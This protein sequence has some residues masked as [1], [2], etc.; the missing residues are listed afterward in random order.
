M[1]LSIIKY[2][3]LC[4]VLLPGTPFSWG[5]WTGWSGCSVTCGSGAQTQSR[6]CSGTCGTYCQGSATASMSCFAGLS[7]FELGFVSSMKYLA[8]HTILL[9]P[10]VVVEHVQW[11]WGCWITVSNSIM[12]WCMWR[13]LQWT[14]DHHT[15]LH[16]WF[17]LHLIL[18]SACPTHF[19]GTPYFWSSW[20]GWSSCTGC[21]VGSQSQTR[22]CQGTC[23]TQCSGPLSQTQ[24]CNIGLA[25]SPSVLFME[26]KHPS[27]RHA[28]CVERLVSLGH[29]QLDMRHRQPVK[30]AVV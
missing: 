16:K 7:V 2:S 15:G 5:G 27:F 20:S 9:F 17:A 13:I 21:G 11:L 6:T 10:M 19:P 4:S 28:V 29:L 24:S 22:S 1:H 25:Q 26:S 18:V 12:P 3:I 8:R 14:H 23:G 30:L